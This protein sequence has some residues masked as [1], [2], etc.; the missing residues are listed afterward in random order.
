MVSSIQAKNATVAGKKTAR[1]LVVSRWHRTHC[2]I[3]SRAHSLRVPAAAHRR[4]PAAPPS[5]HWN[6]AIDVATI[7]D[8]AIRASATV[9]C[10]TVHHQSIKRTKLFATRNP[11]ATWANAPALY[12]WLMGWN[13]VNAFPPK[14][15][16]RQRRASC[17]ANCRAKGI[18][19]KVHLHGTNCRTMCPICMQNQVLRATITMGKFPIYS[20]ISSRRHNAAH[21]S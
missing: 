15:I 14:T 3:R 2:Q 5:A 8:A 13:R 20:A 18:R 11:F 4:V 9:T 16:R 7:M 1:T 19:A 21:F 12:A 10:H 6:S 17:A